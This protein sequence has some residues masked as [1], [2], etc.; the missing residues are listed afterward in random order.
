[1]LERACGFESRSRHS[2][3]NLCK[4]YFKTSNELAKTSGNLGLSFSRSLSD[5]SLY[6]WEELK[7]KPDLWTRE[8]EVVYEK[9]KLLEMPK[10]LEE[11]HASFILCLKLRTKALKDYKL[12][13]SEALENS[14]IDKPIDKMAASLRKLVLSD[15]A[16]LLFTEEAKEILKK[17]KF[18]VSLASSSFLSKDV[19]CERADVLRYVVR[20]KGFE[21]LEEVRGVGIIG[22]STEPPQA[23]YDTARGTIEIPEAN[24]L[25]VIVTVENQG[26]QVEVL[27]CRWLF[28]S[29]KMENM[30]RKK[31][32]KYLFFFLKRKRMFPLN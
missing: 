3:F 9:G 20:L 25:K 28:V 26:N 18:K 5:T 13:L 24:K 10:D 16:Y 19:F 7:E 30:K 21:V 31:R 12:V 17:E 11:S 22:V 2:F 4:S 15:E 23:G 14:E 6:S 32:Q 1:M 27:M 29:L 8:C